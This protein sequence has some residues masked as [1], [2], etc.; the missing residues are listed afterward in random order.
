MVQLQKIFPLSQKK[1][2]PKDIQISERGSFTHHICFFLHPF[3]LGKPA[4]QYAMVLRSAS[5]R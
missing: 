2:F 5:A 3:F 4:V 1:I